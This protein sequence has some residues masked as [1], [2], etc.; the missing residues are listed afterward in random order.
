MNVNYSQRDNAVFSLTWS[1]Y[2][3]ALPPQPDGCVCGESTLSHICGDAFGR[4]A[5]CIRNCEPLDVAYHLVYDGHNVF[6]DHKSVDHTSTPISVSLVRLEGF[7][8]LTG[9]YM[10]GMLTIYDDSDPSKRFV[11]WVVNRFP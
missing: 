10:V 8:T 3:D 2:L 1:R 7:P 9:H 6:L 11:S 5:A 4:T